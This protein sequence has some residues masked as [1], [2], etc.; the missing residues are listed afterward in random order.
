MIAA[1]GERGLTTAARTADIVGV[2]GLL[3]VPGRPP[4]TFT[5][6]DPGVVDE[7]VAAVRRWAADAGRPEPVLDALVQRVEIV[8]DPHAR[9]AEVAADAG[10]G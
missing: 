10:D 5:V 1:M 7:R 4:G 9:A 2:S 6:A 8:D 3:Q